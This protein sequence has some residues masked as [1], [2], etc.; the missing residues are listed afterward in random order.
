[1][2]LITLADILFLVVLAIILSLCA[3][4]KVIPHLV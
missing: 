1:L 3:G 2:L 4:N